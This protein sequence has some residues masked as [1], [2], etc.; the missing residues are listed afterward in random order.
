MRA[1]VIDTGDERLERALLVAYACLEAGRQAA[2]QL[3][4]LPREAEQAAVD[5]H[6]ARARAAL[7]LCGRGLEA[8]TTAPG[9]AEE[10]GELGERVSVRVANELRTTST[11]LWQTDRHDLVQAWLTSAIELLE[12]VPPVQARERVKAT[13][14]VMYVDRA[15][16]RLAS[17]DDAAGC[18]RAI[19]DY[20]Q[21]VALQPHD[22]SIKSKAAQA[23][24]ALGC[25]IDGWESVRAFDRAI[26]LDSGKS[27]YYANRGIEYSNMDRLDEAIEDMTQAVQMD[28]GEVKYR[29]SLASMFNRKGLRIYNQ[30]G[31]RYGA[32]EYFELASG[33]DPGN[34]TYRENLR[35]ARGGF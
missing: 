9:L 10:L 1:T 16:S 32:A 33:L 8:G 2:H 11:P 25:R 15:L 29:S 27:L 19:E 13:L 14:A 21:A 17:N 24:N 18:R 35:A 28:P 3:A 5:D 23:Y 30:T 22:M 31:N 6:V 34:A 12:L 4:P 20:D 26:E 7:E